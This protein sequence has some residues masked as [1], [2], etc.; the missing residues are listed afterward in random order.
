M[1]VT[2]SAA[3]AR[4]PD[5]G[6]RA[7]G[8]ERDPA[9]TGSLEDEV[10]GVTVGQVIEAVLAELAERYE[11]EEGEFDADTLALAETLAGQHR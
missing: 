10:P 8:L 4:C 9:T 7:L 2:D 3:G 5:P 1:V 6:V 11:I